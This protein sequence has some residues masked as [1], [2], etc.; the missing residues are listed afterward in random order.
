MLKR[1]KKKIYKITYVV[2]IYTSEHDLHV[3]LFNINI[4]AN[5]TLVAP[6]EAS[7]IETARISK[8]EVLESRSNEGDT[9]VW[10]LH[11]S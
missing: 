10:T 6:F 3:F 5:F 7:R 11:D 4:G 1:Y 2:T 9:F 8:V